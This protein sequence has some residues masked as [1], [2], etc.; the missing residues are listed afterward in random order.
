[1]RGPLGDVT[2]VRAVP[3][4]PVWRSIEPQNGKPGFLPSELKLPYEMD[5]YFMFW[6]HAVRQDAGVPF[7]IISD[8]RMGEV[9]AKRSAHNERPC[10]A[11]DL[12]ARNSYERAR[13]LIAAIQHGC[14]R[15]GVYPSKD[16]SDG[17]S[18]HLDCSAVNPS[19]RC[20]TRW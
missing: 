8:A 4:H 17:G 9:G 19:P 6:L 7:R 20:W 11:V 5:A 16:D 14:V 18:V 2:A 15:F 3:L 10:R 1:M 13:I 12:Q